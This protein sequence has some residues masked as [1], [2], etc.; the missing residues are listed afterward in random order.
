MN[1]S[2]IADASARRQLRQPEAFAGLPLRHERNRTLLLWQEELSAHQSWALYREV[3]YQ[4]FVVRRI[5]FDRL[6]TAGHLWPEKPLLY[7]S[8]GHLDEA[9]VLQLLV[10]LERLVAPLSR[11]NMNIVL[12]GTLRGLEFGSR[13]FE[14]L[15]A[16]REWADLQDLF[17]RLQERFDAV[18]PRQTGAN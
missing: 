1:S 13:S 2:A 10:S 5:R 8:E 16:P 14:W 17:I 9:A 3:Q 11:R 15:Q 18:L 12:D 4:R 7:C 6:E